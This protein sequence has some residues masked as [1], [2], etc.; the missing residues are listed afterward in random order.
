MILVTST[1]H[2]PDLSGNT[3]SPNKLVVDY[4][5]GHRLVLNM[6]RITYVPCGCSGRLI[7]AYQN[8]RA[9]SCSCLCVFVLLFVLLFVFFVFLAFA[10]A[11][12]ATGLQISK[13][14]LW[15]ALPNSRAGSVPPHPWAISKPFTDHHPQ[16]TLTLLSRN[17][18]GQKLIN[19]NSPNGWSFNAT[20][21][22]CAAGCYC[23]CCYLGW[24]FAAVGHSVADGVPRPEQIQMAAAP[25]DQR[26][27]AETFTD[28]SGVTSQADRY[29][30]TW[31]QQSETAEFAAAFP[32]ALLVS[33]LPVLI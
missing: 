31:N 10:F 8:C 5:G 11:A 17:L 15:Q 25:V 22:I 6:S 27:C 23:C 19:P 12:W 14:R 20:A 30:G 18:H 3:N 4:W 26:I 16:A 29:S 7:K 28:P 32:F 9:S 1:S 21:E 13:N 33:I 2:I 24:A